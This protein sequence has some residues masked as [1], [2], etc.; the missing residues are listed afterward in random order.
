VRFERGSL[1]PRFSSARRQEAA[2]RGDALLRRQTPLLRFAEAGL[3]GGRA[4]LE[5][6]VEY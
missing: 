5:R 3:G 2:R 1:P 6:T 4:E